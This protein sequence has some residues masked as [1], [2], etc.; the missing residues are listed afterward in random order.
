MDVN[1][2]NYNLMKFTTVIKEIYRVVFG[3]R[4]FTKENALNYFAKLFH[5]NVWLLIIVC[6]ITL[7]FVLSIKSHLTVKNNFWP[8]FNSSLFYLLGTLLLNNLGKNNHLKTI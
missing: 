5:F 7:A 1:I 6:L 3:Q 4:I 8:S 2:D